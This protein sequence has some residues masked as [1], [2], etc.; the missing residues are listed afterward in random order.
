MLFRKVLR[1]RVFYNFQRFI[2]ASIRWMLAGLTST[3]SKEL[4]VEDGEELVK[5]MASFALTR[6][7]DG[8]DAVILGHCHVPS[9]N[10]YTVADKKRTF[11]TLGDWIRHYSFLYY[12]NNNF[13]LRYY[14]K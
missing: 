5:K 4:T 1:S 10:H 12:E 2:P 14:T 7:H 6:F 13:F 8:Y 9:I 11:V 3:A